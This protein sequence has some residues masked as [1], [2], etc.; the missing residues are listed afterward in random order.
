MAKDGTS[1]SQRKQTMPWRILSR[2]IINAALVVLLIMPMLAHAQTTLRVPVVART[3]VY[4]P[5]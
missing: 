3:V 1:P 2:S 4:M 5:G